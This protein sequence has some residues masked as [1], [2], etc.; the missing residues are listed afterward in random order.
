MNNPHKQR[1]DWQP[2]R[3]LYYNKYYNVIRAA[4]HPTHT[5]IY[6]PSEYKGEYRIVDRYVG[7]QPDVNGN[8]AFTNIASIY[9]NNQDLITYV[10]KHYEVSGIE[11]PFNQT[12]LDY[13][14]DS[15]RDI[16][17]RDKAWYGQYHHK[18][19]I[20]ETWRKKGKPNSA[21]PVEVLSMFKEL[22]KPKDS[23]WNGQNRDHSFL[24]SHS[25]YF[26][27]PTIY[28]NNEPSIM[29]LKMSYNS[30]LSIYV[31]TVV[32]PDFLK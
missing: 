10:I 15:N 5:K 8:N 29:L 32:T 19:K 21:K 30:I 6:I 26:S 3:K 7:I 13:L 11:T 23:R 31:E 14:Q 17:Y 24:W 2:V 28:T 4:A 20:F 9:T 22:F 16:L 12:H 25:R 27:Y 1:K 18:V